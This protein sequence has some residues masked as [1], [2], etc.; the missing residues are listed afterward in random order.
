MAGEDVAEGD[1]VWRLG[2]RRS[3]FS[4]EDESG[5]PGV[6]PCAQHTA[7]ESGE[8]R[9]SIDEVGFITGIFRQ[10]DVLVLLLLLAVR[11]TKRLRHFR[12][13]RLTND[14]KRTRA[15]KF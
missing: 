2:G 9:M 8:T 10:N 1:V 15:S 5:A 4:F 7:T 11:Y 3:D 12:A 6:G 13:R 14:V